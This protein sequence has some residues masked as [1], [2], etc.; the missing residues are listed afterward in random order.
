[1][2]KVQRYQNSADQ[3][4]SSALLKRCISA[5]RNEATF[6]TIWS[7]IL[8]RHPLVAGLPTNTVR[9]GRIMLEIPLICGPR[10]V[11]DSASGEFF[12]D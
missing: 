2:A 11:D 10:L 9:E 3:E 12:L 8:K 7:L 5:R 6:P 4:T 1:M